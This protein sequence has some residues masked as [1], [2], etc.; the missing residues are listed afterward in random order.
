M[1]TVN[2]EEPVPT[3]VDDHERDLSLSLRKI[4]SNDTSRFGKFQETPGFK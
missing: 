3:M 2:E 4:G 1:L